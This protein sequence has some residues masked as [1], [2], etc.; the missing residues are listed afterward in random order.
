MENEYYKNYLNHPLKIKEAI[1]IY[2]GENYE[3]NDYDIFLKTKYIERPILFPH[4]SLNQVCYTYP[5]DKII[6]IENEEINK[7]FFEEKILKSNFKKVKIKN[8][9]IMD[10]EDKN[11]NEDEDEMT[12]I[13]EIFYKCSKIGN[14]EF[15]MNLS[16]KYICIIE[17]N[18]IIL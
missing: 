12:D 15:T 13:I 10:V 18:K 17:Y 3:D 1:K 8:I 6:E 2:Y 16:S 9:Y 4:Y 5:W 11:E 14:Y 7:N